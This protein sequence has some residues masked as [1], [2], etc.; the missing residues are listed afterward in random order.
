MPESAVDRL[1]NAI[2]AH[3]IDALTACFAPDYSVVWPAHPARSTTGVEFVRRN[4]EA[5]FGVYPTVR[6]TIVARVENGPEIWGEWEFASDD[7]PGFQQRGVVVAE[8]EDGVIKRSRFYMEP[9]EAA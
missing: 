1:V 6:A 7:T 3:D 2:N 9:L 5:I 4:W 8:E